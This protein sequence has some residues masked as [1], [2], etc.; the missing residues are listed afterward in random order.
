MVSY[1][2]LLSFEVKDSQ[3]KT[4]LYFHGEHM[5]IYFLNFFLLVH[6]RRKKNIHHF[7][8]IENGTTSAKIHIE[9]MEP[10]PP[11]PPPP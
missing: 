3:K 9:C 7:K 4:I 11:P 5:C 1:C 2:L 6:G 10:F 8:C